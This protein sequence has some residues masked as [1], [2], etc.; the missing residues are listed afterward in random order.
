M[1]GFW[2]HCGLSLSVGLFIVA[3]LCRVGYADLEGGGGERVICQY[4]FSGA[5]FCMDTDP[6][7]DCDPGKICNVDINNP[8]PE[9]CKCRTWP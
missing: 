7:F 5:H 4:W 1:K 3:A 6:V 9:T 8:G 2:L